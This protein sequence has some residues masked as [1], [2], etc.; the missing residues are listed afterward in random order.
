M[1]KIMGGFTSWRLY[2][3]NSSGGKRKE[4]PYLDLLREI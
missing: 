3:D 4:K 2:R 1:M